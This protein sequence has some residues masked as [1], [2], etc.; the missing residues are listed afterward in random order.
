MY[1]CIPDM[2][3]PSTGGKSIL[4]VNGLQIA[5]GH[6]L[7][8]PPCMFSGDDCS[9]VGLDGAASVSPDDKQGDNTFTGRSSW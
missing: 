7:Q 3:K 8:T 2:D 5:E 4:S 1:E 6:I 9:D